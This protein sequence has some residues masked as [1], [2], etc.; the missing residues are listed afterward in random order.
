MKC[1]YLNPGGVDEGP[2]RDRTSSTAPR[3]KG[4]LKPGG[5][6]VEAT[7]GNTGAG[8]RAWSPPCA[9]TSAIFVMPDKMSQEKISTLR[10]FGAP[11][12]WSA[13]RRSSPTTRAA[14][15]RW[16]VGSSDETPNAV[17]REP[18]PQ[19]RQPR[20]ALPLDG[21]GDLGADQR[22]AS[23]S[24]SPAWAPAAPSRGT[25]KYLKEKKPDDPD[26]RRRPGGLALLRLRQ[27]RAGS[28]SAFSYKVEG[29]G[30]D[31]FPT[32]M[33]LKILDDVVRVDDKEC[34]LMTRDLMRLE[35][36]LRAAARAAPRWRAPSS[37][38][39]RNKKEQASSCFLPDARAATSP[40]SSTT[41]GCARTASSRH[42]GLARHRAR[43]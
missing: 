11:R 30:E 34:F 1:E 37:G 22:R 25:G 18:V 31:F 39:R 5:T 32:T 9:A 13:R 16:R 21:P 7:S 10:A 4:G 3:P 19:P 42:R 43:R 15:T 24:S 36:H 12:S 17:L 20:G 14:T 35:G 23:T 33:N 41:T 6:I 2:H 40:R 26:R 29:I 8:A 28:P 38:R 27:A